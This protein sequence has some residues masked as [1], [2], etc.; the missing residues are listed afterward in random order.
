MCDPVD[1]SMASHTHHHTWQ[2]DGNTFRE[3]TTIFQ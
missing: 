3:Y 2:F 1:L